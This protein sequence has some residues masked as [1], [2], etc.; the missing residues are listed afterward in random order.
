Q[1]LDPIRRYDLRHPAL[2]AMVELMTSHIADPL[3]LGDL[4]H[5]SGIGMR[6]LERLATEQLGQSVMQFYRSLRL[7]KADEILQQSN[8]P[9]VEVALAT[10][11]SN[12]S[13]FS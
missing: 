6:Q 4:V 9:L 13:H 10:G 3:K 8:L 5:L 1:Q 11:F 7:E 2:V 12:R